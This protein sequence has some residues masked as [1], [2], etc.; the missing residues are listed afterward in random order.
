[1]FL[2]AFEQH[3]LHAMRDARAR[4]LLLMQAARLDPHLHADER[5]SVI[6][7]ED[8]LQAIWQR[9]DAGVRRRDGES[10]FCSG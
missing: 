4:V 3:V 2:G 9:G 5:V 8:N 6:L 1:M 10:A 7:T